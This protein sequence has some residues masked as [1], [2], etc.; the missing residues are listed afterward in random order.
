MQV[1][2]CRRRLPAPPPSAC[3]LHH[4]SFSRRQQPLMSAVFGP[5]S[6]RLEQAA[7]VHPADASGRHRCAAAKVEH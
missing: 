5:V 2:A 1:A 3:R 4:R 6:S 7:E